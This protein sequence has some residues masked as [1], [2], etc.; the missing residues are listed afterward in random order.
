MG[1]GFGWFFG[2]RVRSRRRRRY[3]MLGDAVHRSGCVCV[4]R[5]QVRHIHTMYVTLIH[6]VCGATK[7]NHA[8][9]VARVSAC[10]RQ[11][12]TQYADLGFSIGVVMLIR[13]LLFLLGCLYFVIPLFLCS[14]TVFNPCTHA[15]PTSVHHP[16]IHAFIRSP[17]W[18]PGAG[19]LSF[20]LSDICS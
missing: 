1:F 8:E 16:L 2:C 14:A 11:G 3:R 15:P 9:F 17:F 10:V 20:V 19:F 18:S 6:V 13:S 4:Q 12:L 7:K 5:T